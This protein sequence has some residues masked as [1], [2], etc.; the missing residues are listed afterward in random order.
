MRVVLSSLV[1]PLV[2][3]IWLPCLA[4]EYPS[5]LLDL[6]QKARE[7]EPVFQSAGYQKLIVEEG[8]S[9]AWAELLP[10]ISG[11]ADYTSTNQ[12]IESSDNDVVAVGDLNYDSTTFKL[13]LTQPIFHWDSIVALRQSKQ[14]MLL[15]DAQYLLAEHELMIKVAELYFTA[16]AAYDQLD[17]A[18]TELAAVEKHFELASG[19]YDMGLIPITDMLDAKARLAEIT[20]KNIEAENYLDDALQALQEVVGEPVETLK[21]L[22]KD[23]ALVHPDPEDLSQWTEQAL[24]LN[25]SVKLQEYAVEV[26]GLEVDR[27]RAGHY[28]KVD[29]N[30]NYEYR[31]TDGSIYGGGTEG[32]TTDISIVLSVPFYEGGAVSSRVREARYVS[33]IAKQELEKSRRAVVRETRLSYLGVKRALKL[34]DAYQQSVTFNQLTLEAKQEGYLSGIYTSLNVLDTERDLSLANIDY[35]KARYDYLLNS[36]RL[37]QA[38]GTL[39]GEDLSQLEQWLQ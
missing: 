12:D 21:S 11:S 36:L 27:Q 3:L 37:K 32:D 19:R 13:T 5:G 4:A 25:P 28:P 24:Q 22:Q 20:A 38:V 29:L 2:C 23:I 35:A 14:E 26:A 6:Y 34:I 15:S 7:K 30:G 10:K 1:I 33:R 39:T 31:D 9:Q 16:L 18:M 17:F 8:K